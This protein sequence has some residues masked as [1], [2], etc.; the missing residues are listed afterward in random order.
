MR[1]MTRPAARRLLVV[2]GA[3]VAAL[4]G[5]ARGGAEDVA[6]DLARL[7]P[8]VEAPAG[9][10]T[11]LSWDPVDGAATY[12]VTVW[13]DDGVAWMWV[14]SATSVEHGTLPAVDG[15]PVEPVDPGAALAQPLAAG[16][17]RWFVVAYDDADD[18]LAM[19]GTQQLVVADG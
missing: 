13:D 18:V 6:G 12:S 9:D 8:A 11:T 2:V 3:A 16:A 19:S 10:G 1:I 14:G 15:E 7:V 5:C 17:Y 4:A